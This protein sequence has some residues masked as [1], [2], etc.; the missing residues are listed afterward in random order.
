MLDRA[1]KAAQCT[2]TGHAEET[3]GLTADSMGFRISGGAGS[4]LIPLQTVDGPGIALDLLVAGHGSMT[5]TSE[6]AKSRSFELND[7]YRWVR[8]SADSDA[9]VD[10]GSVNLEVSVSD[11]SSDLELADLRGSGV[12]H[13]S[14]CSVSAVGRH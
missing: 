12:D 8:V 6:L 2:T 11:A 4:V 5:V 10:Y 7:E 14:S 13:V 1:C 3:E 9:G